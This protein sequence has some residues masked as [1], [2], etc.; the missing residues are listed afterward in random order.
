MSIFSV[1][2]PALHAAFSAERA[3][4]KPQPPSEPLTK[5]EYR[6]TPLRGTEMRDRTAIGL[7]PGAQPPRAMTA[8]DERTGFTAMAP[9]ST[10]PTHSSNQYVNGNAFRDTPALRAMT[11]N[12]H[13]IYASSVNAYMSPSPQQAQSGEVAD[14]TD[15]QPV[16]RGITPPQTFH[17]S[18]TV[19][20][21]TSETPSSSL[22]TRSGAF[23]AVESAW[24][25]IVSS[26]KN[27]FDSVLMPPTPSPDF[28]EQKVHRAAAVAGPYMYTQQDIDDLVDD[29]MHQIQIH[30]GDM[31]MHRDMLKNYGHWDPH[32]LT[33]RERET[34]VIPPMLVMRT[35]VLVSPDV[36]ADAVTASTKKLLLSKATPLPWS[37]TSRLLVDVHS[38]LANLL[39]PV[40]DFSS[41]GS[42]AAP[43]PAS[44]IKAM[45]SVPP[46][47]GDSVAPPYQDNIARKLERASSDIASRVTPAAPSNIAERNSAING[48]DSIPID[49][50]SVPVNSTQSSEITHNSQA[51]AQDREIQAATITQSTLKKL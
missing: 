27:T 12:E 16:S 6:S 44:A 14:P 37:V 17:Q 19:E 10:L 42:V 7:S 11:P 47:Y 41:L 26:V 32:D 43:S 33:K 38:R 36:L 9:I 30:Q 21:K 48:S 4:D 22:S 50:N 45:T 31:K 51:R 46:P 8:S 1:I 18:Q 28:Y 49:R 39:E 15:V 2:H 5:V 34:G 35:S 24:R 23:D 3:Y 20:N 40:G 13:I 29:I 25:R